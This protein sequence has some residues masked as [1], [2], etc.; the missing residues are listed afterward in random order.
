MGG[1][2]KDE[3]A[4]CT[5][6]LDQTKQKHLN[7]ELSVYP[8][9]KEQ[10]YIEIEEDGTSLHYYT[11]S[12]RKACICVGCRDGV[13]VSVR[14]KTGLWGPLA[15]LSQVPPQAISDCSLERLGT[16]HNVH[17]AGS[18]DGNFDWHTRAR[19]L[20]V[21]GPPTEQTDS[22]V[23]YR[24]P[25]A[26][27]PAALSFT[28][29]KDEVVE[30]FLRR[31]EGQPGTRPL[32]APEKARYRPNFGL[33]PA[34]DEQLLSGENLLKEGQPRKAAMSFQRV[35]DVLEEDD[36]V[37]PSFVKA[38]V[39]SR[40]A[41]AR[42]RAGHFNARKDAFAYQRYY[43]EWDGKDGVYT[44]AAW[45]TACQVCLALRRTDRARNE[46]HQLWDSMQKARTYYEPLVQGLVRLTAKEL[47]S[48]GE[49]G[50]LEEIL[51]HDEQAGSQ[52]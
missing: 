38:Y 49:P 39:G 52:T 43:R 16:W 9:Q 30:I 14:L 12:T 23:H 17:L 46:L 15:E 34:L 27:P 45:F 26:S 48:L 22:T 41:L 5:L 28:L 31:I 11:N 51:K 24:W 1:D 35:L 32:N 4:I 8:K 18:A 6:K 36:P 21:Y 13:V 40:L 25:H 33:P 2:Y 7:L 47:A 10:G 20:E 29:E 44:F 37:N 19:I 42:A 3:F 50:Y